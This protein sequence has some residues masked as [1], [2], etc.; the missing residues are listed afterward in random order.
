MSE[1]PSDKSGRLSKVSFKNY[2]ARFFF[3][4]RRQFI[5]WVSMFGPRDG[6]S[7]AHPDGCARLCSA[8]GVLPSAAAVSWPS[9]CPSTGLVTCS[10]IHLSLW[11]SFW[12]QAR[13]PKTCPKWTTS[14]RVLT[15]T[16]AT[17]PLLPRQIVQLMQTGFR[18]NPTSR[19]R[20]KSLLLLL[21]SCPAFHYSS[22]KPDPFVSE[23]LA[24]RPAGPTQATPGQLL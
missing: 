3:R 9:Y 12:G 13:T 18:L 14:K 1:R 17:T 22:P 6:N 16:T 19:D 8:T 11:S 15:P 23:W 10:I 20:R 5:W 7:E 2:C 4:M 24:A 21:D